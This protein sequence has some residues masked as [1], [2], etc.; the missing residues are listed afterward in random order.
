MCTNKQDRA[1][2]LIATRMADLTDRRR[3]AYERAEAA[4]TTLR[5]TLDRIDRDEAELAAH[6]HDVVV[7]LR[8]K[9]GPAR[10]VYHNADRPCGLARSKGFRAY[11]E[12]EA[13]KGRPNLRRC[14]VC[15]WAPSPDS[16]AGAA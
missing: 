16:Q 6:Q 2:Q 15:D 11:F 5:R 9:L 12:A 1:A 14:G 7:L 8:D 3:R 4:L 13:R 10:T